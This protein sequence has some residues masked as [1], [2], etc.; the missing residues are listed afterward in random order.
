MRPG[1]GLVE[2]WERVVGGR[3]WMWVSLGQFLEVEGLER[4]MMHEGVR[5]DVAVNMLP[6]R[7]LESMLKRWLG[8]IKLWHVTEILRG[9][10][11]SS[12]FGHINPVTY[13][14]SHKLDSVPWCPKGSI[15][16]P[17]TVSDSNDTGL[18]GSDNIHRFI[19]LAWGAKVNRPELWPGFFKVDLT[20]C[21]LDFCV[22]MMSYLCCWLWKACRSWSMP[23]G[24]S[25]STLRWGV[26]AQF[27]MQVDGPTQFVFGVSVVVALFCLQGLRASRPKVLEVWPGMNLEFNLMTMRLYV[28]TLLRFTLCPSER[29]VEGFRIFSRHFPFLRQITPCLDLISPVM[30][31]I[32]EVTAMHTPEMPKVPAL[33]SSLFFCGALAP[34]WRGFIAVIPHPGCLVHLRGGL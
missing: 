3:V 15:F 4:G 8:V 18:G 10:A 22:V 31:V 28:W 25:P 27:S 32:C 24:R 6:E 19:A 14:S 1:P 5:V 2:S 17:R 9:C 13:K 29:E 20:P 12:Q 30:L 33:Y 16:L 23:R 26:V 7:Q 34:L 11:I 21:I